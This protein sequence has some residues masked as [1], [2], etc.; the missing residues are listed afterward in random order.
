MYNLAKA[1]ILFPGGGP[2]AHHWAR[3][4]LRHTL[5]QGIIC[6]VLAGSVAAQCDVTLTNH[7][8]SMDNAYT[9]IYS[10]NETGEQGSFAECFDGDFTICEVQVHL[11]QVGD[12]NR[13]LPNQTLDVFVW[14]DNG[15]GSPGTLISHTAA[16]DPGS[17]AQWPLFSRHDIPLS[18]PVSGSWWVGVRR[19][20][21][22]ST[23]TWLIAADESGSTGCSRV[24]IGPGQGYPIGW[25]SASSVSFMSNCSSFGIQV[26]GTATD[27]VEPPSCGPVQSNYDLSVENAYSWISNGSETGSQGAFAECF[28]VPADSL[29]QACELQFYLT[30]TGHQTNQ[31]LDIY[32]WENSPLSE[33]GDLILH[34][35]NVDPGTVASWPEVSRFDVPVDITLPSQWWVG[36]RGNWAG[37][38]PGW[39][40]AADENG[41]GG[42][43]MTNV[44]PGHGFPIGWAHPGV[45]P[46]WAQCQSLGIRTAGNLAGDS[47]GPADALAAA[48]GHQTVQVSWADPLGTAF[49]SVEIWRGMV[50]DGSGSTAYPDYEGI[51]PTRPASRADALASS[52]WFLSGTVSAGTEAFMDTVALR[53]IYYYEVFPVSSAQNY[54]PPTIASVAATNYILGDIFLPFDGIV[55]VSDAT[56]LGATYGLVDGQVNFNNDADIGPTSDSSNTGIPQPDDQTGFE[57]LMILSM[58]YGLN[59]APDKADLISQIASFDWIDLG[60]RTWAL[61]LNQP[62]SGLRGFRLSAELPSG[63]IPLVSAGELLTDQSAPYFLQN[64]DHSGLDLGCAI[65]GAN[66]AFE[67]SGELLRVV[68]PVDHDLS[69]ISINARDFNNQTIDVEIEYVTEWPTP[70]EESMPSRFVI[71]QNFPNPFNPFT[72]ISFSVPESS[73]VRLE[74]FGIDGK[75]VK[76]LINGRKDPGNYDVQWNGKDESDHPVP[77]GVYFYRIQAGDF[78]EVRKM[79][80]VK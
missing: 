51:T 13:S 65:L 15:S 57:D 9:W 44:G 6:C 72:K 34:L 38:T 41:P 67:G 37:S 48:P 66:I 1:K 59:S 52:E 17:I 70:A 74:I 33:P 75:L 26:V 7:D 31:T 77:T 69:T 56:V 73:F 50:H 78:K 42:C 55:A 39:M 43:S 53:G 16:V 80:L 54:G 28:S 5:I 32:V 35:E 3:Q 4:L 11:S 19:N 45:V 47:S 20:E 40:M 29:I 36:W 27:V 18:V 24:N 68:L 71:G 22:P 12:V 10:G 21:L 25:S 60:N 23:A 14:Q 79:T 61:W 76:V 49:T 62:V 8:G 63:M 58:N 2:G 30:Q 46:A 64:I